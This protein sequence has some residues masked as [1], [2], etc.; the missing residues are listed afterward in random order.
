M[1]M[2]SLGS[3]K[4]GTYDTFASV[5]AC[6]SVCVRVRKCVSMGMCMCASV[7]ESVSTF[8]PMTLMASS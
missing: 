3:E 7:G 5:C 8:S 4:L 2:N 6:A 1:K